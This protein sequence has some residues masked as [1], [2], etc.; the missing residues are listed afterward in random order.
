MGLGCIVAGVIQAL[1][2]ELTLLTK[3]LTI[4]FLMIITL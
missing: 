1:T 4:I 3:T 2:G